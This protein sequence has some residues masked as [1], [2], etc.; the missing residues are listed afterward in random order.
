MRALGIELGQGWFLGEPVEAGDVG[1]GAR[2]E[3]VG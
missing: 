1:R 2:A 3:D